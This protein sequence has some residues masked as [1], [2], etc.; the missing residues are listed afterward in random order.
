MIIFLHK[1]TDTVVTRDDLINMF[2]MDKVNLQFGKYIDEE[3]LRWNY[4][5]QDIPFSDDFETIELKFTV[6]EL[7]QL[8][9]I[10]R[11]NGFHMVNE[12]TIKLKNKIAEMLMIQKELER[13]LN[14]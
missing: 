12:D 9:E 6:N 8:L 13:K 10:T 14:K 4:K 3:V 5:I 1:E 11:G 2:K 7:C